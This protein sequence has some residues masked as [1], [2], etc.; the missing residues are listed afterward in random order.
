MKRTKLGLFAAVMMLSATTAMA[1]ETDSLALGIDNAPLVK[2]EQ[3]PAISEKHEGNPDDWRFRIGGYGEMLFQSFNYGKN[4]FYDYGS[5][6]EKRAQISIP[7]FVLAMDFKFND[8]WT[9]GAEVEFEYGGTGGAIEYETSEAGEY[10]VEI[11]KGGEVALEQF[12]ITKSFFKQLNLRFGHVIVPVGLT[13]AHHEPLNFFTATR[14]EGESTILP[15]TW[16][17][18]GVELF[19]TVGKFDYDVMVING[20]DPAFFSKGNFIQNGKQGLFEKSTMTNPAYAARADF[21]FVPETRI[22]FSFYGAP[23]TTGNSTESGKYKRYDLKVPVVLVSADAVHQSKWITARANFLWG[24]IGES[25]D[26]SKLNITLPKSGKISVFPR[27]QV[28]ERAIDW[29]AEVGV[30]V[31]AGANTTHKLIPFIRYEYYNT[32]YKVAPSVVQDGR[33]HRQIYTVGV[34]Y[35]PLP[36]LVVKMDYNHRQV[37]SGKYNGEETFSVG[38]GYAGWYAF[39]KDHHNRRHRH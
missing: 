19:G 5:D 21:R 11:E 34:N 15:C 26:L 7:R 4:S 6:Y 1:Q 20:L 16:H 25:E 27:T 38:V 13:N 14:S 3:R 10:E 35:M 29:Y 30:N 24:K 31:L 17:E 33:Y 23:K 36:N 32:M 28:A 2:P 9:L 22:G 18:T 12:H 8:T 37:D 39:L